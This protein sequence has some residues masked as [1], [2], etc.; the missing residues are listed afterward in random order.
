MAD[1][2][3]LIFDQA[4]AGASTDSGVDLDAIF[5]QAHADPYSP[6]FFESAW[7]GAKNM[8]SDT[9]ESIK[10]IPSGVSNIYNSIFSPVKSIEDGTTEKALRGTGKLAS[11][12]AGAGAGATL[13]AFGGPAAPVTVPVGAAL[14]AA[15]SLLGFDWLNQ[16]TGSDEPTT[17]EQDLQSLGYN[18]GSGL[19]GTAALKA[20]K[21][22]IE[23]IKKSPPVLTETA[24][25]LDRKSFGTRQSDYGK[26]SDVRTI[27]TPEGTVETP[28]KAALDDLAVNQKLGSSRNPSDM[29][30]IAD[31]TTKEINTQITEAIKHFDE[32]SSIPAKPDFSG[33]RQY[34][35]SGSVPAD[36]VESYASR[37]DDLEQGIN[38]RGG[39]KLSFLQK[40]KVALG[41]SY[42]PADKVKSGFD[43]AI[44][45]DL[46][47]SIESYYPE[48]KGLNAELSKYM[49][50]D[51]ILTRSLKASEGASPASKLR[52]FG[53]TT[54]G[55][56]APAIVGTMLGGPVGTA[57]GATAGLA[58]KAM[59][60]PRGQAT[61][62]KG[63]RGAAKVAR[64]VGP[65]TDF[66]SKAEV[67]LT[68][69]IE[70]AEAPREERK[71]SAIND[72]FKKE[73]PMQDTKPQVEELAPIKDE[74]LDA[75]RRVESADGKFQLSKAGARGE[76]QFMPATA[77]AYNVD[78]NDGN[79]EDDRE[80]AWNL[81][82]DEFKALGSLPL[83]LASYNA[84]RRRV[85]QAIQ[86]AGSRD[87]PDVQ[88]ALRQMGLDETAD[89]VTKYQKLGIEV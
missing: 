5:D 13:G 1:D 25:A 45:N 86:M 74:L 28:V 40:Q 32:T 78:L 39:G 42:D 88:A 2:L 69:A 53:Y 44:Y 60:T 33:A 76:Y 65:V 11:G 84:G 81:I 47:T 16:A 89:Y 27:E 80:G 43:R 71:S 59:A 66:F 4:H 62:A 56:G 10:S 51:P 75:V 50:V 68:G 20:I 7:Q 49:I 70:G 83:A 85:N 48:I 64:K 72:T 26:A 82:Q 79:A 3:D 55:I 8:P 41:K 58:T 38:T 23:L 9:L 52:D 87:W 63:L 46:K 57:I 6:G 15:A 22:P 17:P 19:A 34:L 36:L 37:L 67:P 54:G 29:I 77:K 61:I 21:A 31:A 12:V 18:T 24:N 35:D 30:K 73:E 14:G